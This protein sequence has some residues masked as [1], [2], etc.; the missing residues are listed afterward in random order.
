MP[1]AVTPSTPAGSESAT[2]D[3]AADPAGSTFDYSHFI[4]PRVTFPRQSTARGVT[5]PWRFPSPPPIR[6]GATSSAQYRSSRG[7]PARCCSSTTRARTLCSSAAGTLTWSTP[8]A[9]SPM[10]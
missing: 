1:G 5:L 6:S 10:T 7:R 4:C 9:R 2:P 3:G 8:T